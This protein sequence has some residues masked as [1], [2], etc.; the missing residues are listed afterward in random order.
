MKEI[1]RGL[2][3]GLMIS[4]VPAGALGVYWCFASDMPEVGVA[5]GVGVALAEVA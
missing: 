3:I 5:L 4:A 2:V 1:V